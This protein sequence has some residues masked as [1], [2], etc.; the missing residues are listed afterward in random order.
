VATDWRAR[1]T[2]DGLG[3]GAE[4]RIDDSG[5][6]KAVGE[7]LHLQLLALVRAFQ[8]GARRRQ[9]GIDRGGPTPRLG[10]HG[11]RFSGS[12]VVLALR[13]IEA[14][15]GGSGQYFGA[16]AGAFGEIAFGQRFAAAR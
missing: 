15:V 1:T 3:D 11:R 5:I 8:D 14:E 13:G 12:P 10:W 6:G 7:D 16:S 2:G 9:K 4:R